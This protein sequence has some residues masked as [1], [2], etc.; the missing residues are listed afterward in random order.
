M[1]HGR[2][3]NAGG[4]GYP[5]P[6]VWTLSSTG[7]SLRIEG[8]R[9]GKERCSRR[10]SSDFVRGFRVK[11][12]EFGFWRAIHVRQ[13]V[14][15]RLAGIASL[16][17]PFCLLLCGAISNA[18]TRGDL[19]VLVALIRGT[20][21][22]KAESARPVLDSKIKAFR[23]EFITLSKK[24]RDT[25]FQAVDTKK[26]PLWFSRPSKVRIGREM[27]VDVTIHPLREGNHP[28]QVIWYQVKDGR[29]TKIAKSARTA[30]IQPQ[31]AL[32]PVIFTPEDGPTL[33]VGVTILKNK[34]QRQ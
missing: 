13:A 6:G 12:I 25:R 7:D 22:P 32:V 30:K 31:G 10:E 5:V 8:L 4:V 17:I 2:Y 28:V 23:K 21:D 18:Q 34:K 15:M 27:E 1:A 26:V 16:L 3:G 11:V 14:L 24:I 9:E 29:R 19:T 20:S 33:Y